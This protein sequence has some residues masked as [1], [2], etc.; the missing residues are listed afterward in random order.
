MAEGLI[1]K[2]SR[3]EYKANVTRIVTEGEGNSVRAVG[4]EL[5]DGRVFRYVVDY[6][7]EMRWYVR[8]VLSISTWTTARM[9]VP[10]PAIWHFNH[11]LPVRCAVLGVQETSRPRRHV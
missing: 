2:G 9:A 10:R 5:A 7:L 11:Y 1:E 6:G 8:A 3:I 4:V